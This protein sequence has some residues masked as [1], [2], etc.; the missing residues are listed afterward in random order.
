MTPRPPLAVCPADFC[1]AC[2]SL[3]LTDHEYV[4]CSRVG[5][6]YGID[7]PLRCQILGVPVFTSALVPFTE[8][9]S[10]RQAILA[11]P[12]AAKTTQ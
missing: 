11:G 7:E 4:W 12:P 9:Q 5:C 6:H 3:L 10:F 1:P 8:L 2:C